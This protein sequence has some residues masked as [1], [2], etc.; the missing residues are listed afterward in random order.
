MEKLHER[1]PGFN[2]P[3]CEAYSQ[4]AA[5][6]FSDAHSSPTDLEI[7]NEMEGC[8]RSLAWQAPDIGARASW[9][10]KDDATRDGAYAVSLAVVEGELGFVAL[11]RSDVRTG[12][13]YYIGTPGT[14]LEHC[15]RLE[16]SGVREGR[17][18]D[19]RTRLRD[20]VKQARKGASELP[21]FACAVG[22]GC[23]TILLARVSDDTE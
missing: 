19:V 3:I 8:E 11:S 21:A 2:R 1:H 22:F 20:K 7:Y 4:A 9:A 13:D 23:R 17:P 5:V 18:Q 10:N 16:V 15:H 14:D 12:A 6:C